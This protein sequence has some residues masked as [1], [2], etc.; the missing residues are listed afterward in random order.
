MARNLVSV[1]LVP[2]PYTLCR[3]GLRK[4]P[5]TAH[6]SMIG[7]NF[8]LAAQPE[9]SSSHKFWIDRST[10]KNITVLAPHGVLDQGFDGKKL[11]DSVRTKKL[12]MDLRDA[13][14]FASWGM[15]DWMNFIRAIPTTDLY[16]VEVS[17]YAVNQMNLVTGLIGHGKLTSFYSPY[18]CGTCQ[19]EFETLI[20]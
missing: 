15:A 1:L 14:R 7:S 3:G 12:V 6:R 11:A 9:H 13:R 2:P 8:M 18:R 20:V 17:T 16:L 5:K 4:F 10:V 19:E